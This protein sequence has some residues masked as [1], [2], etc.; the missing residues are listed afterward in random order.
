MSYRWKN[1]KDDLRKDL[2]IILHPENKEQLSNHRL[3]Y[4]FP[5]ECTVN[6]V[7]FSANYGIECPEY[8]IQE[9]IFQTEQL[10]VEGYSLKRIKERANKAIQ[11]VEIVYK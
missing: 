5:W 2:G 8:I 6:L 7:I 3:R 9:L 11:Y 1:L 4:Y 10:I